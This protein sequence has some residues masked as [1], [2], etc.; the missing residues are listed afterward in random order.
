MRICPV[1]ERP[2]SDPAGQF[3]VEFRAADATASPHMQL[4]AIVLAGLQGI[5]DGLAAPTP[6]HEDLTEID[7]AT[8]ER[9]GIRALPG[10][11]E[12]ALDAFA[13]DARVRGFFPSELVDIYLRHKRGEVAIMAGKPA[14]ELCRAYERVY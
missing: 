4:A 10:S 5:A 12:A 11:L 9:R 8:L 2:G 7:A 13:A 14:D 1:D 3:N 6:T